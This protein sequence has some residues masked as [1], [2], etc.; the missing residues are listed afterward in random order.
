MKRLQK[1]KTLKTKLKAN[2]RSKLLKTK[3]A[4]SRAATDVK[5]KVIDIEENVFAYAKEHPLK[6]AGIS[7]VAGAVVARIVRYFR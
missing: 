4:L 5:D 2:G 3:K 7:L 1:L 6:T